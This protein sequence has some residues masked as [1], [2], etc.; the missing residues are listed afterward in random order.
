MSL[1]MWIVPKPIVNGGIDSIPN[2]TVDIPYCRYVNLYLAPGTSLHS[3][4][5]CVMERNEDHVLTL[6]MELS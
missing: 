2:S 5:V 4:T 1:H 3:G 6:D